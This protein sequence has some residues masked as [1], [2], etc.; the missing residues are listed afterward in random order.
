[1]LQKKVILSP[2][3]KFQEISGEAVILDLKSASYF[4]LDGV[5]TRVWQ[6]LEKDPSLEA[7]SE[8]IMSE[9]D[10][11][12]ERLAQDLLTLLDELLAAELVSV[13]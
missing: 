1:M 11:P 2:D 6:L 7:A 8:T 10:V 12:A 5:G 4:G 3:A 13:E 9:F